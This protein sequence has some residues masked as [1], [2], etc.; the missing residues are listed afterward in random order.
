MR[1]LTGRGNMQPEIYV[2]KRK[3]VV[4]YSMGI[5]RSLLVLQLSVAIFTNPFG[6]IEFIHFYKNGVPLNSMLGGVRSVALFNYTQ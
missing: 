1:V 4:K 3:A 2:F 5:I 6:F